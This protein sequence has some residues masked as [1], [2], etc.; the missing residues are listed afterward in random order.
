MYYYWLWLL[1][2]TTVVITCNISHHMVIKIVYMPTIKPSLCINSSTMHA[3]VVCMDV[4]AGRLPVC[5]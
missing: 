2:R 3:C 4:G 1:H 5:A